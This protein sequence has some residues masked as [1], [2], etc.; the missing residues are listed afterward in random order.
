MKPKP[1][2]SLNHFTVP[3]VRINASPGVVDGRSYDDP[4]IPTTYVRGYPR[5]VYGHHGQ[6]KEGVR[7]LPKKTGALNQDLLLRLYRISRSRIAQPSR[8]VKGAIR[9]PASP[10]AGSSR[11]P[12]GTPPPDRRSTTRPARAPP[13]ST[14]R[15]RVPPPRPPGRRTP[16]SGCGARARRPLSAPSPPGT[17]T[18]PR[19]R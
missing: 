14:R 13:P 2:W 18:R 17:P 4:Y 11:R 1:F 9:L 7:L 8:R 16:A 19:R 5:A 3:L 15:P 12:P 6:K 10:P